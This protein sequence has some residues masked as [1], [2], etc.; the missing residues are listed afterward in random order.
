MHNQA[1]FGRVFK[2]NALSR[3]HLRPHGRFLTQNCLERFKYNVGETVVW[4]ISCFHASFVQLHFYVFFNFILL[5]HNAHIPTTLM[6]V[7]FRKKEKK[8]LLK[9]A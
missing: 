9:C 1:F 6:L 2:I 5:H 7:L 8:R 4:P 3:H